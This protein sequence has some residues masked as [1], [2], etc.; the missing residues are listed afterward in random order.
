MR[1]YADSKERQKKR[2]LSTVSESLARPLG[3]RRLQQAEVEGT[4][5]PLRDHLLVPFQPTLQHRTNRRL[6]QR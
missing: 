1:K 4:L 5:H 3:H 6:L 2:C